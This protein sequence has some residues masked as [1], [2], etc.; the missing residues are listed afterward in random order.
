MISGIE[1]PSTFIT[2]VSTYSRNS[3]RKKTIKLKVVYLDGK[4]YIT[5]RNKNSDWYKNLL[6]KDQVEV[7]LD[8]RIFNGI[9][10]ELIDEYE[11][12]KISEIKYQNEKKLEKR[13]GFKITIVGEV[14]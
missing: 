12:K 13:Y 2:E 7:N 3:N 8:G 10:S 1:S 6:F 11:I 4:I 9:A 14:Q 5:R